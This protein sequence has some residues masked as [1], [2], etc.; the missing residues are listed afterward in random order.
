MVVDDCG[1]VKNETVTAGTKDVDVVNEADVLDE[2][3]ANS[4]M[5]DDLI[6]VVGVVV[7]LVMVSLATCVGVIFVAARKYRRRREVAAANV[8]MMEVVQFDEED[9]LYS[10]A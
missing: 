9:T 3:S 10:I 7:G 2:F 1:V 6:A 4:D 5:K 8:F